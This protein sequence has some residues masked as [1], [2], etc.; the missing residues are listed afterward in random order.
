MRKIEFEELKKIE[1]DMLVL[2]D[3]YCKKHGLRYYLAY[4]TLI[5]AARHKG[6]IPWDDDIDIC[7]PR[8]DYERFYAMQKDEP[9]AEHLYAITYRDVKSCICPFIKL[10]DARTAGH[11]TDKR[12]EFETAVWIDIFPMDG[13]PADDPM[14]EKDSPRLKRLV[15]LISLTTRP[16]VFTY[17][18]L[19]LAKRWYINKR[20]GKMDVHKVCAEIE[21]IAMRVPYDESERVGFLTFSVDVPKAIFSR[22]GYDNP[23]LMDF[24]GYKFPA[25]SNYDEILTSIYGDYMT[26][27]P[28]DKREI[29]PFDAWWRDGFE[30][31][32]DN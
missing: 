7:M 5:G 31:E 3:E 19:R 12:E 14:M 10:Q 21:E 22:E 32:E 28:E 16:F 2:F 25:P 27:P 13:V 4:G 30:P 26:P 8:P 1:L 9:V 23:I 18:P 24:E 20:Y 6:F 29:H 11:E 17:D 15:H